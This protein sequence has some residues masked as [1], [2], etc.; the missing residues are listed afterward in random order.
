MSELEAAAKDF[1]M[2]HKMELDEPTVIAHT[3]DLMVDAFMAGAEFEKVYFRNYVE[4][5]RILIQRRKQCIQN[6]CKV[7]SCGECPN[8]DT[9]DCVKEE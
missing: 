9:E 2:S 6:Y 1:A 8:A 7:Y 5:D 3:I 4:A